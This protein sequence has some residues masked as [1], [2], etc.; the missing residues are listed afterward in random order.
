[1]KESEKRTVSVFRALGCPTRYKIIKLLK[2]SELCTTDLSKAL[3]KTATTT[4]KHLKVLKD[5][6]IVKYYTK[7]KKVIYRLKNNK[8][9]NILEYAESL[10]SR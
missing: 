3:K 7:E 4:S 1:M 6:G 2:V 5:L 10:F 9:I 8:I